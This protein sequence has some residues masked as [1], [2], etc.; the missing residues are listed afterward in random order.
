MKRL[1]LTLAA[2]FVLAGVALAG[3]PNTTV[4]STAYE[5]SH[6]LSTSGGVIYNLTVSFH[7]AA[8][9]T[10]MLFDAA[11]LPANGAVTP[12]WCFEG[13]GQAADSTESNHSYSWGTVGLRYT[14]GLVAAVSTSTSGCSTIAVDGANDWFS[15]QIFQ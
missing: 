10:I 11:S 2:I 5:G 8:V 12:L 15:A 14:T 6:V 13:A 3:E 4:K 9:R 1:F 7:T